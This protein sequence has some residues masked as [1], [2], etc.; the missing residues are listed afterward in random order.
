M[1]NFKVIDF[2][3]ARL[4][5]EGGDIEKFLKIIEIKKTDKFFRENQRLYNPHTLFKKEHFDDYLNETKEEKKEEE[6]VEKT[7][8]TKKI[9]KKYFDFMKEELASLQAELWYII[10]KYDIDD[11]IEEL[12]KSDFLDDTVCISI[13]KEKITYFSISQRSMYKVILDEI[14][15]KT[16]TEYD[17]QYEVPKEFLKMI[18]EK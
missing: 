7:K 13:S 9:R 3:R 11:L 8:V 14:A 17:F 15:E 1:K 2:I 18:G 16:G 12:G 5:E 10:S 6:T 4:I